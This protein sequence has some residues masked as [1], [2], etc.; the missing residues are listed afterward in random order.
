MIKKLFLL[1]FV[2]LMYSLTACNSEVKQEPQQKTVDNDKALDRTYDPCLVN[3]N[4]P[5]CGNQ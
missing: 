4:L 5:V 2:I 3:A 1:F